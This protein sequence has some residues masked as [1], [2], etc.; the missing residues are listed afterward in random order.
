MLFG[1]ALR[2]AVPLRAARGSR[3]LGLLAIAGLPRS[4]RV[5]PRGGRLVGRAGGL[6]AGSTLFFASLGGSRLARDSASWHSRSSRRGRECSCK[7][8]AARSLRRRRPRATPPR[9]PRRF[10][11]ARSIN[12]WPGL[13]EAA[14]ADRRAAFSARARNRG[15]RPI[16]AAA[17]GRPRA[18]GVHVEGGTAVVGFERADRAG[19][20]VR[21]AGRRRRR[22]KG[23]RAGGRDPR[24]PEAVQRPRWARTTGAVAGGPGDDRESGDTVR[25]HDH[26][27]SFQG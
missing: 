20:K 21:S 26:P 11:G 4:S 7:W 9:F 19:K 25:E 6:R 24:S 22:I 14:P 15:D 5:M 8:A 18:I 17:V 10:S 3:G 12:R 16:L 13:T 27:T 23:R 1:A 2:C